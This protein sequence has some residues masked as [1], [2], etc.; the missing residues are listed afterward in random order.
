MK[1]KTAR[2]LTPR[3][4]LE[5]PDVLLP[6]I[7]DLPKRGA[8]D[9]QVVPLSLSI[10]QVSLSKAAQACHMLWR[11]TLEQTAQTSRMLSGSI[12]KNVPHIARYLF[13]EASTPPNG[14]IP[15]LGTSFH[16]GTSVRYPILPT[17]R[18]IFGRYPT[19]TNTKQF[20]NTIAW[21]EKF[22]SWT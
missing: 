3:L 10:A 9:G 5:L 8:Q 2:T 12:K 15:R 19:K 1:E 21:Y 14:A 18:A 11:G 7:R 6:D 20:S 22:R 16:S 17:Y 13:W 4:G